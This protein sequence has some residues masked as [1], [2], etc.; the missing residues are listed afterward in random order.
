MSNVHLCDTGSLRK[1]RRLF[2]NDDVVG[3]I[4]MLVEYISLS[5]GAR[6]VLA[7]SL[8]VTNYV[9]DG[10]LLV[11]VAE[12]GHLQLTHHVAEHDLLR[13]HTFESRL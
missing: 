11:T 13:P 1:T 6:I 3:K 10:Y 5:T 4:D 2:E 8:H 7:P 9:V 12:P